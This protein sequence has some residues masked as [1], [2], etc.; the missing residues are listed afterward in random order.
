M[1]LIAAYFTEG[2]GFVVQG[3]F[4]PDIIN[5]LEGLEGMGA[6][7]W[8]IAGCMGVPSSI[9][10]M[11]LAAKYGSVPVIITAMLIQTVGILIPTLTNNPALNILSGI[12][13]GGTFVGLVALFLNLGGKLAKNNPVVLMG[14]LTTAYGVGQVVG[15]LYASTL[16]EWSG[17]YNLSLYVTAFI[18]FGGAMLLFITER[19]K[20]KNLYM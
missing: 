2:L 4:L 14:A 18:V 20:Q 3:T 8:L 9:L 1:L 17:N 10:W 12:F 11:R 13:Y 7:T 16:A 19:L 6:K 15:P 5:S